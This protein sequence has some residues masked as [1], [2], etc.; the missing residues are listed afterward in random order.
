MEYCSNNWGIFSKITG[1]TYST[2]Q[3]QCGKW[4][5]VPMGNQCA[6]SKSP[7]PP[8]KTISQTCGNSGSFPRDNQR[9]RPI[10]RN[11]KHSFP[12]TAKKNFRVSFQVYWK[13]RLLRCFLRDWPFCSHRLK[14][15]VLS[16][17]RW[18]DSWTGNFCLFLI[19]L[20]NAAHSARLVVPEEMGPTSGKWTLFRKAKH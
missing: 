18:S 12:T 2:H 13:L 14:R 3:Q 15:S 7:K 9:N 8:N 19:S 16:R 6:K 10:P 1:I 5:S 4:G 11:R 20:L 17:A